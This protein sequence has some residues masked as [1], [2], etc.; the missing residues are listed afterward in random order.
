MLHWVACG[1]NIYTYQGRGTS[2]GKIIPIKR[3]L[4]SLVFG[5]ISQLVGCGPVNIHMRF[6]RL[7]WYIKTWR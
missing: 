7:N 2:Q 3:H 1:E 5:I 4:T 6:Q